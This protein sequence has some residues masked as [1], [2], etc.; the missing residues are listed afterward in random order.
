MFSGLTDFTPL[1]I[2]IISPI[3]LLFEANLN[4]NPCF[5]PLQGLIILA[6]NV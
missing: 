4:F 6:V 1:D 2:S 5:N 3:L